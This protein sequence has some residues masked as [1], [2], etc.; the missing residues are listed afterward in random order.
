MERRQIPILMVALVSAGLAAFTVTPVLADERGNMEAAMRAADDRNNELRERIKREREE[1]RAE[2]ERLAQEN[3]A[4]EPEQAKIPEPPKPAVRSDA[5]NTEAERKA[6]EAERKALDAERKA[7][8]AERRAQEALDRAEEA[9]RQ[10]LAMETEQ[11][12]KEEAIKAAVQAALQKQQAQA[13]A[14][15]AK[16]KID[17]AC[18]DPVGTEEEIARLC[19]GGL[20]AQPA[21]IPTPKKEAPPAAAARK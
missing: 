11:R 5:I 14:A 9:E 7:R 19:G 17:D 2:A 10:R 16:A 15:K 18:L 21:P 8:D 1:R 4:N 13:A 6:R 12:T 20:S 3:K